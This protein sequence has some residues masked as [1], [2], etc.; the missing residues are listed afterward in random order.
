VIENEPW[1]ADDIKCEFDYRLQEFLGIMCGDIE[2]TQ[3]QLAAAMLAADEAC[4]R[5]K[6]T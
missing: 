3:A 5:L 1:T 4:E 2:P 6:A